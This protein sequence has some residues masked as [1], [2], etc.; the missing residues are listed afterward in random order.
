[1]TSNL[2]NILCLVCALD[3]IVIHAILSEIPSCV[4]TISIS[5]VFLTENMHKYIVY[6]YS[7]LP[8]GTI[9]KKFQFQSSYHQKRAH[10]QLKIEAKVS[11]IKFDAFRANDLQN[12]GILYKEISHMPKPTTL[13]FI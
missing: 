13:L 2:Y 6:V 8:N 1:M 10:F 12:Q 5:I 4:N 3:I 7:F 9:S 11:N